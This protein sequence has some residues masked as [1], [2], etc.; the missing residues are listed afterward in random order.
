MIKTTTLCVASLCLTAY[1]FAQTFVYQIQINENEQFHPKNVIEFL[2]ADMNCSNMTYFSNSDFLFL[3]DTDKEEPFFHEFM[4]NLGLELLYFQKTRSVQSL[5][6]EKAGGPDCETA[7][8]LCSNT[9][10]SANS[11]GFGTVQ[12]L[13]GINQGCMSIEHQSSWYYVNIGTGGNL[14]MTIDPNNNSDDYDFAIWG[15]FTAA[16]AGANCPPITAP[17]RCSWSANP[18]QTGMMTPY[19]GQSSP[20]GCGFF[21]LFPCTG[22]ITST[23]NPVDNSEGAGGDGWVNQLTVSAGQVY[24]MLVDNF[25]NSGQP[26]ALNWGGSAVLNCTPI[27]LP[28][29]LAS[30][31]ALEQGRY[32][33]LNWETFSEL[34]NDYFVV[35]RS[36]DG[37]QWN[38]IGEVDGAGQSSEKRSYSFQDFQFDRV[39]NYYRL[40]QVNFD[41]V[42]DYSEIRK[43]DNS[44]ASK[45]VL[46]TL[47]TLGQ[48]VGEDFIGLK[49]VVYTDGT[50]VKVGN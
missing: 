44:L 9:S 3:S 50:M 12:E 42:S 49:I 29:E 7:E 40:K 8:L 30:F 43:V 20:L 6:M 18:D 36:S 27:V 19:S 28:V 13:N 25:S 4:N 11:S 24:V 22:M 37:I 26:Y 21:G 48:E 14:T 34:N 32:N 35:E 15:P 2:R 41:G 23:N 38:P 45:T 10:V 5:T 46:K 47:N 1:T 17:I 39:V 16:T 33:L 31:S